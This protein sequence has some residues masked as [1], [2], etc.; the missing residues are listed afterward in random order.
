MPNITA[1]IN[2]KPVGLPRE[3]SVEEF[4]ADKGLTGRR[5]AVAYNG[6]V[7]S[8]ASYAETLITHGDVLEVVRPVGGG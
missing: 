5:I 3:M 7:V 2:G 8:S 6:S 4:L 1:T